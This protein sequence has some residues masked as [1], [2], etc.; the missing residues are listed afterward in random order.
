M[1]DGAGL[2]PTLPVTLFPSLLHCL[3]PP[4]APPK[5]IA[6]V[7][8]EITAAAARVVLHP[9]PKPANAPVTAAAAARAGA[10]ARALVLLLLGL[11]LLLLHPPHRNTEVP[12]NSTIGRLQAQQP[13][14]LINTCSRLGRNPL[15]TGRPT[16]HAHLP[17]AASSGLAQGHPCPPLG[18]LAHHGP[19]NE[20]RRTTTKR[21]VPART[22]SRRRRS[23]GYGRTGRPPRQRIRR[24]PPPMRAWLTL[25]HGRHHKAPPQ[26]FNYF[27]FSSNFF[28]CERRST[29]GTGGTTTPVARVRSRSTRWRS[30]NRS[31]T[32]SSWSAP[33][34][35]QF[36]RASKCRGAPFFAPFSRVFSKRTN[37]A[38]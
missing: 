25:P 23:M 32:R 16:T 19:A 34:I 14:V 5:V 8:V 22:Q 10:A 24:L 4:A 13:Y 1:R 21:C 6:A 26:R 37:R 3:P 2:F 38:V 28:P 12:H 30:S 20:R 35:L 7:D 18:G 11:L 33:R 9:S 31:W 15:H 29:G 27:T 17:G 36:Q